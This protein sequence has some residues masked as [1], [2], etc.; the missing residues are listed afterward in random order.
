MGWPRDGLSAINPYWTIP[1]PAAGKAIPAITLAAAMTRLK[2]T[3][4]SLE[5]KLFPNCS[6][7]GLCGGIKLVRARVAGSGG[8]Q[9]EALVG[10]DDDGHRPIAREIAGKGRHHAARRI[11]GK[12]DVLFAK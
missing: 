10:F 4:C 9:R 6:V 7:A 8:R 12:D 3:L 5:E 2:C 11:A 1:A